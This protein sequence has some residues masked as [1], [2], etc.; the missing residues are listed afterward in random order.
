MLT[1]P[2]CLLSNPNSP[3]FTLKLRFLPKVAAKTEIK[4]RIKRL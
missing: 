3:R 4:A 1:Y 2:F